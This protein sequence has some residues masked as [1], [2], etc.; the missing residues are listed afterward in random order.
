MKK[1][2]R[3][4]EITEALQLYQHQFPS[5]KTISIK[6]LEK[7]TRK[8]RVPFM[9]NLEELIRLLTE[10][11]AEHMDHGKVLHTEAAVCDI[12]KVKKLT[13]HQWR[14]N[15]NIS[16]LSW[17]NRSIRYDL[18]TLLDELIRNRV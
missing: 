8:V 7:L 11:I 18:N 1:E 15:K 10:Y 2:Y 6:E 3:L 4:S 16:F 14:K 5:K 17:N 12:L 9:Y 13:M